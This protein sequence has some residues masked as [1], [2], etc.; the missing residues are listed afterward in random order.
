MK[1][2]DQQIAVDD[3]FNKVSVNK[4]PGVDTISPQFFSEGLTILFALAFSKGTASAKE[5]ED[6][7]WCLWEVVVV[8]LLLLLYS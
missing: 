6:R 7:L 5:V 4:V 3:L 8:V 2:Q 1:V